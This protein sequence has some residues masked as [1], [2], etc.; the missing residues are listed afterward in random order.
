MFHVSGSGS[1]DVRSILGDES[2]ESKITDATLASYD[3]DGA[4]VDALY[5]ENAGSGVSLYLNGSKENNVY[6]L[7]NMGDM[8]NS[9]PQHES[10]VEKISYRIV[11]YDDMIQKG[12]P[13][14]G[15]V[16]GCVCEAGKSVQIPL[17]RLLA[18]LNA[19][20]VHTDLSGS[21]PD[22]L[23]AT[24]VCNK[25][26]WLR[27]ANNRLLPFSADGS[28][29]ETLGDVLSVSDYN[30]ELDNNHSYEG[31]LHISQLGPGVGYFQDTTVVLYVP[32][33]I[34]GQLLPDNQDPFE[35]TADKLSELEDKGYDALCTYLEL[36]VNKP[37]KG[38]G[39]GGDIMYRCYL[40]E[41]NVSDFSIVRNSCYDVAISLTDRG[42]HLD[43]WKVVR[44]DS[45]TDVRTV[46]FVDEPY[47]IYPGTEN[48]VILHYNR[49]NPSA[50]TGSYGDASELVF[51]FDAEAMAAAGLSCEFMGNER[52]AGKNGYNDFYFKVTAASDAKI[53]VSFPIIAAT[54]DGV[55][56][57]AVVL[58]VAEI[59]DLVPMWEFQPKYVSQIGQMKVAGTVDGLMPLSV[60]VA[61]PSILKCSAAGDD[62]FEVTALRPGKTEIVITNKDGSQKT[63]VEMDVSAPELRVSE[64]SVALNP[65]GETAS[66]D[67]LYLDDRGEPIS[68]V[69]EEVYRTY[70]MPVVSGNS[71]IYASSDM[72]SVKMHIDKLESGGKTIPSGEYRDV[73]ITAADCKEVSP[74]PLKIY[75]VDPFGVMPDAGDGRVDD[76]SLLLGGSAPSAI[77]EYFERLHASSAGLKYEVPQIKADP[78]YVS[79]SLMPMWEGDFSYKNEAFRGVYSH[80]DARS[81]LGASVSV[82]EN[83]LSAS[84][85]HGA[86][87]HELALR[88]QNRHSGEH[89]SKAVAYIDFYVHAVIGASASFGN[90]VSSYPSGGNLASNTVAGI[91]N[92]V[93]GT[94]IYTPTSS[95]RIYYMDVSVDFLTDVSNV[96]VF[97]AMRQGVVSY[98]NVLNGLDMISPSVQDGERS[99]EVRMMY[100]V[101]SSGGERVG[102]CGEAYGLRKGIGAMQYRALSV[103]A[104]N[105]NMSE[106]QLKTLLLGYNVANGAAAS[107]YAPCYEIHDMNKG[108]DMNQNTVS[109]YAPFYFSPVSFASYRDASG[110]GYH[111]IYTLEFIA[112]KTCG[113]VNLL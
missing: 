7:V 87:K 85:K 30:S 11:S 109:K 22:E 111:V 58:R 36:N 56:S 51:Q 46:R 41:D 62:S 80:N 110:K 19:R 4:I 8:T 67:Y 17:E 1:P 26:I 98:R 53:G 72:I 31:H 65:D 38:D 103:P 40:G 23:F 91:Y 63:V 76:Y 49:V 29:A 24:T 82:V 104:R 92:S 13:M 6:A 3:S 81:S 47:V 54:A 97:N 93:A 20:I 18:K 25:S 52:I 106:Q 73:N 84:A 57:D 15:V 60:T 94:S 2:I 96:L 112:P 5:Y 66:L 59:G 90:F 9:F 28:R 32:E 75:F 39:F 101:C 43:N 45:W 102:I 55:K 44:S 37:S 33:N 108:A 113:W 12:I 79:A 107:P 78:M 42:F 35:K 89:L 27:Q 21:E 86:G 14:C 10:D 74:H 34:Q 105:L 48:R 100:S 95:D 68:N 71:Y 16:K 50:D 69:D 83:A 61:D 70:L 77:R 64:L 99:S 88:V